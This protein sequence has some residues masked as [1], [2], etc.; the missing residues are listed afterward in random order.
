M[1]WWRYIIWTRERKKKKN[2][3][4]QTAEK[5]KGLWEEGVHKIMRRKEDEAQSSCLL[6]CKRRKKDWVETEGKR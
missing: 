2:S 4:M 5:K 3:S 1:R 6:D